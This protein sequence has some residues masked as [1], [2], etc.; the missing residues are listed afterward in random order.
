MKKLSY[1]PSQDEVIVEISS[2]RDQPT[3][4]KGPFKIW[5]DEKHLISG[6]AIGDLQRIFGEFRAT[7]G[8]IKL[9]GLWRN[10][11]ITDA[12]IKRA[13]QALLAKLE[14]RW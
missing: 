6:L 12:D 3:L 13:R 2:L 1:L 9:G 11:S 5:S 14:E 8:I 10:V 4:I 7:R